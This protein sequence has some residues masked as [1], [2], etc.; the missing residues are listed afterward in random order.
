MDSVNLPQLLIQ[1][2]QCRMGITQTAQ[3]LRYSYA[4]VVEGGKL[5]LSTPPE[6]RAALV[7]SLFYFLFLYLIKITWTGSMAYD[8]LFLLVSTQICNLLNS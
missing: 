7:V 4:A 6:E 8:S 2:R 3:Q 1:L 5:L